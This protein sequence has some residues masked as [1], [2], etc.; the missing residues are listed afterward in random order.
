LILYSS[1]LK[2][3]FVTKPLMIFL[4]RS[5]KKLKIFDFHMPSYTTVP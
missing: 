1:P 2:E 5:D 3:R 4:S